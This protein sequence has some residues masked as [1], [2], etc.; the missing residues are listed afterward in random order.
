[1]TKI[2]E[3]LAGAGGVN[4]YKAELDT[5]S[6]KFLRALEDFNKSQSGEEQEHLKAVMDQQ[7]AVIQS[8]LRELHKQGLQTQAGV[9]AKDY[10]EYREEQTQENY[11]SLQNDMDTLRELNQ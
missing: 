11:I 10:K 8:A 3:G 9:V 2:G 4:D 7:M 1:M 5:S 6:T